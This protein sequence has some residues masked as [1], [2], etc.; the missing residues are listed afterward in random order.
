MVSC[1]GKTID[2]KCTNTS[3]TLIC[4]IYIIILY[5]DNAAIT[6]L[7]TSWTL[8]SYISLTMHLRDGTL[9]QSMFA[10]HHTEAVMMDGGIRE[11]YV[12]LC[13]SSSV[14][15][16]WILRPLASGGPAFLH[17]NHSV[18]G[19]T[20]DWLAPD[21]CPP[22]LHADQSVPDH[23]HHWLL[24]EPWTRWTND[25]A[26][27]I[28]RGI[29]KAGGPSLSN[30]CLGLNMQFALRASLVNLCWTC[31]YCWTLLN[32]GACLNLAWLE[33]WAASWL[34]VEYCDAG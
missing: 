34:W 29:Q 17:G 28:Y 1:N 30:C 24:Q 19:L 14:C 12:R 6:V 26:A 10:S 27:C 15:H 5:V 20:G 4:L 25:T 3:H 18:P 9:L 7:L 8:Q 23:S 13:E 21:L 11:A 22:Q 33:L 2:S 31:S 16:Y 32:L